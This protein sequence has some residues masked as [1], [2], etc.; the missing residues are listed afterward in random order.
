MS[1][2][3]KP[4]A[5]GF[6]CDRWDGGVDG[7]TH[8]G[9][10]VYFR[11][12]KAMWA[13]G[14]GVPIEDGPA[15]CRF[16]PGYK[17]A[18][19]EL[20]RKGKVYEKD[21]K[22]WNDRAIEEHHRAKMNKD[23]ASKRG[24]AGAAARHGAQAD[25]QAPAQAD[26][27]APHQAPDKAA[28]EECSSVSTPTPTPLE[29]TSETE[30]ASASQHSKPGANDAALRIIEAFDAAQ[31]ATYAEQR[32]PWPAQTDLATARRMLDGGFAEADAKPFFEALL[33]RCKASGKAAPKALAYAEGA[34]A[35][36][37]AGLKRLPVVV[38]ASMPNLP[39][40]LDR[41]PQQPAALMDPQRLA[42]LAE[43]ARQ[44]RIR[45]GLEDA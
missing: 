12:C 29:K 33:G 28:P 13:T 21:G 19:A 43:Q 7:L 23:T 40:F 5:V 15:H 17:K 38:D 42:G 4:F 34:V 32:R 11:L 24:R 8:D 27:Q 36:H 31:E 18:L 10:Y 22:L 3:S 26:T 20:L 30:R 14:D 6:A 37:V 16:V 39:S 1:M 2:K 41:R 9:E 44:N 35:E 45:E 25:A